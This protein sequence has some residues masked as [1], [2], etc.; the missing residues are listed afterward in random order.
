MSIFDWCRL[1]V[2]KDDC[3]Y[4]SLFV[5]EMWCTVGRGCTQCDVWMIWVEIQNL[6]KSH[7]AP[8]GRTRPLTSGRVGVDDGWAGC[9]GGGAQREPSGQIRALSCP[10]EWPGAWVID[11]PATGGGETADERGGGIVGNGCTWPTRRS[12]IKQ[13]AGERWPALDMISHL[14]IKM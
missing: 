2:F 9:N 5:Y 6:D 12:V 3:F 7:H 4:S 11:V 10:P 8:A 14:L 13:W 1:V